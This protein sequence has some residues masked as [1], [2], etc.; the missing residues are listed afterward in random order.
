MPQIRTDLRTELTNPAVRAYHQP[1]R[2][3]RIDRNHRKTDHVS[4]SMIAM[5]LPPSK[6]SFGV[7]TDGSPAIYRSRMTANVHE[8]H[9]D[10]GAPPGS[11]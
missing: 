4:G 6:F 11:A 5:K 9:S 7:R 3:H 10:D 8:R 2:G 1:R